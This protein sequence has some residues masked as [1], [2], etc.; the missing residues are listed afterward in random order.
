MHIPNRPQP[1]MWAPDA[2]LAPPAGYQSEPSTPSTISFFGV[3]LPPEALLPQSSPSHPSVQPPPRGDWAP[4]AVLA[5]P[6]G[7]TGEPS[8]PSTISF[9]GVELPPSAL[10]PPAEPT[11]APAQEQLVWA[12]DAVLAAPP[13]FKE[14]KPEPVSYFGMFLGY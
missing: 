13:A 5:P 6:P 9:F 7:Y 12:P 14:E 11:P 4:D 10:F 3:D 8:A 1:R 2:V